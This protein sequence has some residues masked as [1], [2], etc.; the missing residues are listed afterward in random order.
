[1]TRAEL[2]AKEVFFDRDTDEHASHEW[3]DEEQ[4]EGPTPDQGQPIECEQKQKGVDTGG[5][6]DD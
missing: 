6:R 5:G 2:R 3:G 1:M 4:T